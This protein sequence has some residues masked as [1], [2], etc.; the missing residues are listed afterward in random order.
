MVKAMKAYV[1]CELMYISNFER[2]DI[3]DSLLKMFELTH[4]TFCSSKVN[5]L[6]NTVGDLRAYEEG[7]N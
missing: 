6:R 5:K 4:E 7:M 1:K 2:E 3:K